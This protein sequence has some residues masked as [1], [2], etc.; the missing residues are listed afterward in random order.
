MR[1]LY[2]L[3]LY[4][5]LPLVMLRLLWRSLRAPA[6]RQRLG[7]PGCVLSSGASANAWACFVSHPTG[8]GSGSMPSRS[9]RCRPC[10]R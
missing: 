3:L 9:A 5:L 4:L 7:C 6:Y 8:A 10:C 2:T 1:W